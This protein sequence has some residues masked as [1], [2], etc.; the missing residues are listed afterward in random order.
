MGKGVQGLVVAFVILSLA[1]AVCSV[2]MCLAG[3]K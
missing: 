2:F 3:H 1:A